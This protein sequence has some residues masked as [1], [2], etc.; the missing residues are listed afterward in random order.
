MANAK[1]MRNGMV[2]ARDAAV[3]SHLHALEPAAVP[4]GRF[5]TWWRGDPLSALPPPAGLSIAPSDDP[6]IGA[7]VVSD[8]NEFQRRLRAGNQLWLARLWN[9]PV[10]WG[11]IASDEVS[12]GELGI[13]RRLPSG[14]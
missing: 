3:K 12:I 2:G 1:A 4:V 11:W 14:N 10:G 13:T 6:A 9:E 7:L 5:H 8:P